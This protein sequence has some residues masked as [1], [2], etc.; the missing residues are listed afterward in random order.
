[1]KSRF[2]LFMVLF[3][4]VFVCS[5]FAEDASA[6]ASAVG[7]D[8]LWVLIAAFMVFIMQAGFGML[9]AGLIRTKNTCNILMNNFLDFCMASMGFLIFGYAIMFGAGNAFMGLKGWF[10]IDAHSS[11]H[12]P[13]YAEWFFHVV[14]CGA[15]ATIVAGG[16]QK[17]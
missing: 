9:E 15:A 2:V 12:L 13:L 11:G 4:F 7:I 17:G 1:M 10:L 6:Y 14:F 8:T 16:S 5:T 3:S